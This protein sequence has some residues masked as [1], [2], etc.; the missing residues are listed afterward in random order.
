MQRREGL[1][2]GVLGSRNPTSVW[3]GCKGVFG[4]ERLLKSG[5]AVS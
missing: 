5:I 3:A 1:E 4:G 2:G